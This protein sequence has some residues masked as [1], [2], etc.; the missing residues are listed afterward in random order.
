MLQLSASKFKK[1]K[2]IFINSEAHPMTTM[3]LNL[4]HQQRVRTIT[5]HNRNRVEKAVMTSWF[6]LISIIRNKLVWKWGFSNA[7]KMIFQIDQW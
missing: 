5:I 1:M 4:P 6:S 3:T 7:N 2:I